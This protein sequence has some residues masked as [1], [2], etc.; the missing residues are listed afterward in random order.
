MIHIS[1]KV[2]C[3]S[4][5]SNV[6][7]CVLSARAVCLL[8]RL[9]FTSCFSTT[10]LFIAQACALCA[11]CS[12]RSA[13]NR[14]FNFEYF[15]QRVTSAAPSALAFAYRSPR[16]SHP[17]S[18]WKKESRTHSLDQKLVVKFRKCFYQ[19]KQTLVRTYNRPETATKWTVHRS[20][21]N[22]IRFI[23][24]ISPLL[25]CSLALTSLILSTFS[26]ALATSA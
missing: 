7:V 13:W 20:Q 10:M 21:R 2:S 1:G 4:S 11:V 8:Y 23:K 22:E 14:F 12:C 16:L 17:I 6:V 19:T 25:R 26:N 9:C 24:V 18:N 5:A 3:C 15:P